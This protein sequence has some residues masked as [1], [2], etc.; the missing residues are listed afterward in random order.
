MPED[1][2]MEALYVLT[3]AIT[4]SHSEQTI[5]DILQKGLDQKSLENM[6]QAPVQNI[7]T[8]FLDAIQSLKMNK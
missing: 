6:A 7:V 4:C 5:F 2:R 3:N 1:I 8:V